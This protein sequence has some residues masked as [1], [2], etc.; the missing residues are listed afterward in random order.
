MSN[1]TFFS[2]S[3]FNKFDWSILK[4][5]EFSTNGDNYSFC[6]GGPN[7]RGGAGWLIQIHDIEKSIDECWELPTVI[8]RFIDWTEKNGANEKVR[9]IRHILS[10][11]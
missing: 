7:Y 4:H 6:K 8:S 3:D 5:G 1:T 9:E 10:L 11:T 2:Q